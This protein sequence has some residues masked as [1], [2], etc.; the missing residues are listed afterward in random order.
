L[1][2]NPSDRSNAPQN[3][4]DLHAEYGP[5][6]LDR[7]HNFTAS[8]VYD[9]PWYKTQEGARGHVL[10]GWEISG[11]WYFFTGSP[12][13]V[14][15]STEDPGGIGCLIS[16]PV[17]CRPDITGNPNSGAQHTRSSFFVT[18]VFQQVPNGQTRVGNSGRGVVTGP[19]FQ[20]WDFALFKNT[21]IYGERMHLQFRAEAINLFNH[22]NWNA[23]STNIIST[24]KGQVTSANDARIMQLGL[25]LNF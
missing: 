3:P 8:Y 6:A 11:L 20:R 23:V 1:T 15:E 10:G 16:S 17:S 2:N 4:Y 19:R 21:R 24:T 18:S 12:L 9:L 22:T 14:T 7:R 13:T 5:S 25:K